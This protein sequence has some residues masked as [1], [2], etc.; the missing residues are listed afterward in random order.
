MS[1]R[2]D[3]LIKRMHDLALAEMP[4]GADHDKVACPICS[5][6]AST[7][8]PNQVTGGENV[9]TFTK[10]QHEQAL[11]EALKPL[12]E[13]IA[14]LKAA[15]ATDEVKAAVD[16]AK[17]ESAEEIA[18]LT[19]DL[20]A[21]QI[22]KNE[23]VAAAETAKAEFD[24]FKSELAEL[25]AAEQAAAEREGRKAERIEKVKEVAKFDDDQIAAKADRWADMDEADF[26]S[27]VEDYKVVA[28]K[29]A[30]VSTAATGEGESA[31]TGTSVESET[32]GL[33]GESALA[34]IGKARESGY[35]PGAKF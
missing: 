13:E 27:L 28:E 14:S 30:A 12:Q 8:R 3:L 17:A 21:A 4:E 24:A 33:Q 22:E 2:N 16:A 32:A 10:E 7:D 6:T 1:D 20:D 34:F 5:D 31:M 19:A 29:A 9:E 23:A 26:A 35:V 18:R 25:E 11:A 15:Q